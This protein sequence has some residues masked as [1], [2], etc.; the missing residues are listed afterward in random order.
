MKKTILAELVLM[1]DFNQDTAKYLNQM[2][3]MSV[4][5]Y[6]EGGSKISETESQ[7]THLE[8]EIRDYPSIML[9]V[10]KAGY[11]SKQDR[12]IVQKISE[13]GISFYLVS[14]S[15]RSE[16]GEHDMWQQAVIL[17]P[18]SNIIAIHDITE[19]FFIDL[20]IRSVEMASKTFPRRKNT[21]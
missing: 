10:E 7:I 8:I 5:G 3:G 16:D 14:Y 15:G 1:N 6:S 19:Q 2:W 11:V 21:G 20:S 17:V 13:A 18:M 9:K 4:R 12:W